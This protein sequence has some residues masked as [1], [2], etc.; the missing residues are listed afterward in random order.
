MNRQMPQDEREYNNQVKD[1]K[2]FELLSTLSKTVAGSKWN[3]P[4]LLTFRVVGTN[5]NSKVPNFLSSYYKNATLMLDTSKDFKTLLLALRDPNWTS[6]SRTELRRIRSCFGPFLS[7]LA[8]VIE[9]QPSARMPPNMTTRHSARINDK[10]DKERAQDAPLSDDE[11]ESEVSGVAEEDQDSQYSESRAMSDSSYAS[12]ST[13]TQQIKSEA[14]TNS[15][16]IEYLQSLALCSRKHDDS[17][18]FCLEWS[19]NQDN[20]RFKI[21]KG[22]FLNTRNDGGLIHRSRQIEG[23][24]ARVLPLSSY[25]SIEAS[26]FAFA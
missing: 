13:F 11:E 19:T 25:C 10:N 5:S 8:D 22:K 9:K 14:V 6:S 16:I 4:E 18:S 26:I 7:H 20:F 24:W 17:R 15:L 3:Y 12:Q 21:P 1:Y 23:G 2:E